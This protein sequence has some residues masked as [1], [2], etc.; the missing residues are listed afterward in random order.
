MLSSLPGFLRG[1]L[2]WIDLIVLTGALWLLSF[3]PKPLR[4]HW[5]AGAFHFWC[6]VFVRALGVEL[7]LHQQNARPLPERFLM[8]ANHPSAFEDIGLPALFA[9]TSLA[10]HEVRHWWLVGRIAAAAG[11]LFVERESRESRRAA[12]AAIEAELAAG[13]NVAIYPE[14]GCKGRRIAPEFKFGSFDVSLRTGIPIV[15]VFIHYEA[16]ELFEWK[17]GETL[18]QKLLHFLR[19]PNPRA[20]YYVFDAFDPAQFADKSAY[21]EHVYQQYLQWQ[22]KYLE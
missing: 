12:T 7:R 4:G 8:I 10:K 11:T 14:G 9:V 5:Y 17:P 21:T 18:P 19:S 13:N 3:L 15:P 2:A 6:R 1:L 20:N 22:S 16:Q